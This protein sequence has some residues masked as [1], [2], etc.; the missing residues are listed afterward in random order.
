MIENKKIIAIIP[1]R[2]GSKGLPKKNIK[3]ICGKPLIVWSIEHAQHSKY[4]DEIFVSTD[5][6]EIAEVSKKFGCPVPFLRPAHLATDLASP[7]DAVMD[8]LKKLEKDG[9]NFDYL[10]LLQPTSPLREKD[11]VDKM[12][13]L[14]HKN[15]NSKDGLCSM[16]EAVVTPYKMKKIRGQDVLPFM[17]NI[18]GESRRQDLESVY[19]PFGVGYVVKVDSFK[20]EKTFYP[21]RL[22]P[23][24]IARHQCYEIDDIY[25]HVAMEAVMKHHL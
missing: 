23:Y 13:E 3:D 24:V 11:D 9:K 21:K 20:G 18:K 5:S 10:I 19:F 14:L 12:I 16:G 25:D 1:A 15:A 6:E 8:L 17:E 2:G 22:M 4:V 7:V